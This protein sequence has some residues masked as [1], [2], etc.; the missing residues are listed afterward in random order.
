MNVIATA[1]SIA[2]RATFFEPVAGAE[3]LV[4]SVILA[5]IDVRAD[6]PRDRGRMSTRGWTPGAAYSPRDIWNRGPGPPGPDRRTG[7]LLHRR[8]VRDRHHAAGHRH[9]PTRRQRAFRAR[10]RGE[11]GPGHRAHAEFPV[12]PAGIVPRV[13]ARVLHPL[14][15]LA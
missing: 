10:R 3:V 13:P 8:R 2:M 6:Q 1:S 12:R 14:D 4:M 11:Q 9:R 7:R 5:Y 15:R